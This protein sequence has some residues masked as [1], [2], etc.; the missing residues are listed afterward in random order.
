MRLL[1]END[2]FWLIGGLTGWLGRTADAG[3]GTIAAAVSD[4]QGVRLGAKPGGPLSLSSSDK[5]LG[6]LVLPQGMT[7]DEANTLYLLDRQDAVIKRF[8]PE[9]REFESLPEVGGVGTNAREFKEPTNIAIVGK[10]LYVADTGNRRVQIFDLKSLTLAEILKP[11]GSL[12]DWVPVDV[13]AYGGKVYILDAHGAAVYQHTPAGELTMKFER[14]D[15]VDQWSRIVVDQE[16]HIFLLNTSDAEKPVLETADPNAAPISDAGALRDRFEAPAIRLDEKGRFCLPPSLARVCGREKPVASPAPEIQLALCSPFDRETLRCQKPIRPRTVRT[17][18][19]SFLLYVLEREE[20]RVKAYTQDGKRLRH[21][22]GTDLDWEPVDV[23][24]NGMIACVLDGRDGTV[25]RHRAGRDTLQAIV[26]FPDTTVRFSR[27]AM[28]SDGQ[29]YLFAP[30]ESEVEIFDCTGTS[31]GKKCYGEVSHLFEAAAPAEVPALISGLVFDRNGTPITSV[32]AED[33]SGELLYENNGTWR[34]T[35]L[36]SSIYRCQWHRLEVNLSALPPGSSVEVKTYAFE[37]EDD[38]KAIRE[39]NWNL[40][41]RI[42]APHAAPGCTSDNQKN[43]DFLVQSGGGRFLAVKMELQGDGFST[44]VVHSL[45]IHYPRDS[46]LKYLPATWSPDDESRVF[47]ERFL[48]LFQ[49]EWDALENEIDEAEKY[50]DP[51]AV[52]AGPFLDHLASQWLAL[53]LEGDWDADQKRRM[54]SA[55]P[56]AYPH[57]GKLA[58]LRTMLSV[59]LANINNLEMDDLNNSGFPVIVEGFREREHLFLA[60]GEASR[61]G[62]AAQLW[63]AS[64]IKRLQV[65]VFSTEGEVELVSTGDPARDVFHR[66]AHRFRVF[67]P[68]RWIRTADD[69]RMFRRAIEAEKPAQ[70]HYDLCLLQPSFRVGVQSTVEV[71]T[72]IGATP[73]TALGCLHGVDAPPS[74]TPTGRLGLDTVLSST[75]EGAYA[76]RLAPVTTLGRESLSV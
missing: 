19:G 66:Y 72:I 12:A 63:S 68:A 47:L 26:S 10:W 62:Q 71:D 57:R 53:P 23:A 42:V 9:S 54:L 56:K 40:A 21:S 74:L 2:T 50:F 34:S 58:G 6:G 17:A 41:Y 18:A 55:A 14:S 3:A 73:S 22:W 67:V 33:A 39:E 61:L 29:I 28:D 32:D 8:D 43:F 45:K 35:P 7:F 52:P 15:R 24:A 13:A 49:T 59:Y 75:A 69:E 25:Y 51:D 65:G 37:D 16:G 27:I 76:M 60:A 64:V 1:P 44:P 48:S 30:G 31:C 5:S 70:T 38:G 4:R 36:D 20:R 11:T 46:Y